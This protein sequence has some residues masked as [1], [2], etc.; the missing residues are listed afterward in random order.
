MSVRFVADRSCSSDREAL[1]AHCPAVRVGFA[2][3]KR[4]GPATARN[5]L[6]RRIRSVVAAGASQFPRGDYLITAGSGATGLSYQSLRE[7][8][9]S[10]V[11]GIAGRRRGL[12]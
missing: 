2:I 11:A 6:R 9:I 10:A 7:L 12:Q 8:L 5:R 1:E 4:L 3:P